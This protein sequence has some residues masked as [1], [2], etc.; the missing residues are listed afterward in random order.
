M[1][2]A[3]GDLTHDPSYFDKALELSGGKYYDALVALGKYYFDKGDLRKALKHLLDGLEIKPLLP[4]VWFRVGI[5]SMQLK[6]WDTALRAFTEVVQ[7]EP[8]EGD[9]WANVAAVHMQR[10][11]PAEA[12]PALLESLKQNR[13]NW[14]VWVNKLYTCIDLKK[15]DEAIQACTE[16]LNLKAR[17]NSSKGVPA[18][19]EKCI[20]A[21]V[22]GSLQKY[23]DARRGGDEVA[24]DSSKRTLERVQQLMDVM[25]SSLKS[26][27]WLYEISAYFNEEMGQREEV[28]E[29]LMKEYRTLQSAGGWENDQA[30]ISQ[31][32][33]LVKGIYAHHK[34]D[35]SRG[36]LVK[37]KLLINGVSKKI[38]SAHRDSEPPGEAME[39]DSLLLDLEESMASIA[40]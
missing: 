15:Y 4:A 10:K 12:Y 14:R 18:L 13:N 27:A 7:Q 2:A 37:C 23:H 1:Y 29:D 3:L 34:A 17:S 25:K 40:N 28:F 39:L 22:G 11:N 21:I 31:M 32:T 5:I 9:A 8:S 19:E 36:S 35:G 30:K 16:L 24:L 26:E 38:G 6:E 33:S 20:R